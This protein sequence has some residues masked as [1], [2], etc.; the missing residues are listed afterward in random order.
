MIGAI[1]GDI[2]GSRFEFHNTDKYDFELFTNECSFTDDTICTIA[3]ANALTEGDRD[4]QGWLRSFCS[5]YPH[6]MGSYGGGFAAWLA[7]DNPQPYNSF[8]NG[9]AMRVSPVAWFFD[10]LEEVLAEA[11][12]TALPTH[13]HP[14]GIRGAVSVAHAIFAMRKLDDPLKAREEF[15]K[16]GE[17]YYPDFQH[18]EFP[19]GH[20][21]ESC[22]GTVPLAFRIVLQ[23]VSFEDAIRNAVSWGGDSDTLAAIVGS[24]AEAI[25]DVPYILVK[26]AIAHLPGL[27]DNAVGEFYKALT[28]GVRYE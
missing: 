27:L 26:Q 24:I 13:N 12:R 20:F 19:K 1:I 9:A 28:K 4:Y 15:I 2:V 11:E 5:M 22:M 17:T 16:I 23:S 10:T 6:P 21:D 7:S 14:E 8:G 18:T 3:I 25:W